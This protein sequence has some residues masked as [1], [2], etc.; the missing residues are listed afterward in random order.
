[1]AIYRSIPIGRMDQYRGISERAMWLALALEIGRCSTV[2]PGVCVAGKRGAA[3]MFRCSD[4]EFAVR[5]AELETAGIIAVDW[6]AHL[7]VLRRV[8]AD[9]RP[10]NPNALK[11]WIK[12]FEELPECA[13]KMIL[14]DQIR[15]A[16]TNSGK[17]TWLAM[18]DRATSRRPPTPPAS[19]PDGEAD[20]TES[21][22]TA[23]AVGAN[24]NGSLNGSRNG[25]RN[26]SRNGSPNPYPN[27]KQKQKQKQDQNKDQNQA[28]DEER[29]E[30]GPAARDLALTVMDD[31]ELLA[32]L[33]DLAP[34][35]GVMCIGSDAA[36]ARLQAR[37]LALGCELDAPDSQPSALEDDRS[38]GQP[39][40]TLAQTTVRVSVTSSMFEDLADAAN[41]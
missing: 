6:S 32:R 18:W 31:D 41:G 27:Q 22:E 3:E 7:V 28:Q 35:E 11:A 1:M 33:A 12:Q 13:L 38:H 8:L 9:A 15:A 21:S 10:A 2:I 17:R 23:S 24:V 30:K 29:E 39:D 40:Q 5:A 16:L 37:A 34:G 20:P 14:G 25:S 19:S 36:R 4:E 26:R